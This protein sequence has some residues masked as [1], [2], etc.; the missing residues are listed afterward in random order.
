VWSRDGH[1]LVYQNSGTLWA[2]DVTSSP[3][4]R[5]G[6]AHVLYQG[7]IWND[8]GAGPNYAL[9]PDGRRFVIVERS[10]DSVESNINVILNWNAELLS[11]TG[12]GNK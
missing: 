11:L 1:R 4:F 3:G 8:V 10:K 6:K 7:D 2:V 9:S 12:S 5:V